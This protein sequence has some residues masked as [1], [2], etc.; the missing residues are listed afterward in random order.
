MGVYKL[1]WDDFCAWYL[2]MIKP[3]YGEPID[4]STYQQTIFFFEELMKVLH[5]F[6]PF[7]TEEIWQNLGD[8][9]EGESICIANYP[10]VKTQTGLGSPDLSRVFETIQQIRN[11]RNA[12]GLSPKESF[13]IFV[14][15]THVNLYQPY[16][17]LIQ[18][19]ANVS[20]INFVNEKVNGAILLPVDTDE[21]YIVLNQEIDAVEE[22]EKIGREIDYLQG[23]LKSVEAKLNNEK[24]VANAKPELVEKERQKLADALQKIEAL[25]ASLVS[26][27]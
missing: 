14:K 10:P 19:L 22:K 18:K 23:F 5:P 11:L 9:K 7:I 8:R 25:K 4:E 15:A 16:Q 6:M 26:I 13:E 20:A 21:L 27:G 17:Y 2:E 3:V 12:K 1:I 24:F